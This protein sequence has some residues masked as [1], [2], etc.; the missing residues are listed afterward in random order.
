MTQTIFKY[1]RFLL[2]MYNVLAIFFA[3]TGPLLVV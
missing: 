3:L 2:Y 1:L